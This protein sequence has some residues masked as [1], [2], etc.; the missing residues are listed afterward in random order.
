[1]KKGVLQLKAQYVPSPNY[2]PSEDTAGGVLDITSTY[3]EIDP[4]YVITYAVFGGEGSSAAK[5]EFRDGIACLMFIY[6]L[7]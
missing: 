5:Y 3:L 2:E 4:S 1:M 7:Y 6:V